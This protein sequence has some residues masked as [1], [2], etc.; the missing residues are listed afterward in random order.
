MKIVAG[1]GKN[2]KVIEAIENVN[3]EVLQTES[4]EELVKLLFNGH[5]DAAIRG[6]LSASKIMI[7]L[8]EKYPKNS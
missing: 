5:A 6:S 8:R 7:K 2:K 1:V 3:F 4:E